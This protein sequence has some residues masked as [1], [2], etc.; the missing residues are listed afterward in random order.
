MKVLLGRFLAEEAG[1][2]AIEYG[3]I[4]GAIAGVAGYVATDLSNNVS[5]A[6]SFAA[7]FFHQF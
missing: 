5:Q 1:T 2:T 4:V 3:L 6:F 7:S